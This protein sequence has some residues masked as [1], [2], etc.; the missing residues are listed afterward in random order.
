MN[1]STC[2]RYHAISSGTKL[3]NMPEGKSVFKIYYL[4][5]IGRDKPELYEWERCSI[6]K[7][8]FERRLI[9]GD[10][11]GVGFITAFPHIMK[12][13]RFSPQMET[14]MDVKA[15]DP[16]TM[17]AID[18]SRGDGYVEFACYA[19][20]IIAADEY[21]AWAESASVS[22]YLDFICKEHDFPVAAN[23][24]MKEYWESWMKEGEP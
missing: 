23:S 1:I 2:R 17:T 8:D 20:A 9:S 24:K 22:Q 19:E 5:I 10:Y 15:F 13:F 18:C 4:S 7:D 16:S 21:R 11:P 3:L 12:I 6:S 14:V